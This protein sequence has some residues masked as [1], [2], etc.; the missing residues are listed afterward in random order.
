VGS[1]RVGSS[2][3]TADDVGVTVAAAVSAS[4]RVV[5][6]AVVET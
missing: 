6:D 1:L 4:A 3:L 2:S 5:V